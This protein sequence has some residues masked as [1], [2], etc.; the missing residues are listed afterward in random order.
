MTRFITLLTRTLTLAAVTLALAVGPALAASTPRDISPGLIQRDAAGNVPLVE[1]I[2]TVDTD[3]ECLNVVGWALPATATSACDTVAVNYFTMPQGAVV[4]GITVEVLVAGQAG[5]GCIGSFELNG[6]AVAASATVL[7][8]DAV[9]YTTFSTAFTTQVAAG[10]EIGVA[11]LDGA[12]ALVCDGGTD[13]MLR[14]TVFGR[15]V[16]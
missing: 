3:D 7:D 10:D 13:P 2:G 6:T 14:A 11:A 12:A 9:A 15:W 5:Y 16:E 8:T 4:T 1:F